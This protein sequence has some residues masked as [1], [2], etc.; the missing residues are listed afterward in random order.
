MSD[1]TQHTNWNT[2]RFCPACEKKYV[3]SNGRLEWCGAITKGCGW[4][5]I[6]IPKVKGGNDE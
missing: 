3:A 5:A 2:G 1:L 4:K 6:V